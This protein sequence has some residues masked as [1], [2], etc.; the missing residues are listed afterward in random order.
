[1]TEID[2]KNAIAFIKDA[3]SEIG[4]L[5]EDAEQAAYG[6]SIDSLNWLALI[7]ENLQMAREILEESPIEVK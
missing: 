3:E 5:L 2:R 7:S 4:F 1:M 6:L